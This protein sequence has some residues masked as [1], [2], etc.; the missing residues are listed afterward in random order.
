LT[1]EVAFPGVGGEVEVGTL[2]K[3]DGGEEILG[4]DDLERKKRVK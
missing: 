4:V 3:I 2:E 1:T